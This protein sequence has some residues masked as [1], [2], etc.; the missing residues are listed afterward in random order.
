M[1]NLL[2]NPS[3]STH[4]LKLKS[5]RTLVPFW[6]LGKGQVAFYGTQCSARENVGAHIHITSILRLD[7][8]KDPFQAIS[9]QQDQEEFSIWIV[10]SCLCNTKEGV[11]YHDLDIT[12]KWHGK[13]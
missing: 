3:T 9:A 11:L 8:S 1:I 5:T 7:K 4:T 10:S 12:V 2:F 6:S 13:E